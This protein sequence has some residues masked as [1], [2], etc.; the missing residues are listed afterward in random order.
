VASTGQAAVRIAERQRQQPVTARFA[1]TARRASLL[2]L[3]VASADANTR[4]HP[5]ARARSRERRS[6]GLFVAR[7]DCEKFCRTSARTRSKPAAA[8][9]N[10]AIESAP[11]QVSSAVPRASQS[12]TKKRSQAVPR[13]ATSGIRPGGRPRR[14]AH[15]RSSAAESSSTPVD[16]APSAKQR[17]RSGRRDARRVL[18]RRVVRALADCLERRSRRERC[19]A[20]RCRARIGRLVRR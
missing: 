6:G 18:T 12:Q 1:A 4:T 13:A 8:G 15:A 9:S 19:R 16:I 5:F 17:D 11:R 3:L 14:G 10:K 2:T 20:A 7:T